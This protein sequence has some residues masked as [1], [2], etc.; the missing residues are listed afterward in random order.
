MTGEE[1]AGVVDMRYL[2]ATVC[3]VA[4]V[5]L[6]GCGGHNLPQPGATSEYA[7]GWH[8]TNDA[9]SACEGVVESF[10][11]SQPLPTGQPS[12]AA[13]SWLQADLGCRSAAQ[14]GVVDHY[15][16][17]PSDIDNPAGWWVYGCAYGATSPQNTPVSPPRQF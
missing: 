9:Y 17:D 4:A 14:A 3:C 16:G 2:W 10:I 11:A 5:I 13:A 6:A 12:A 15:T 1:G 8:C 7:A